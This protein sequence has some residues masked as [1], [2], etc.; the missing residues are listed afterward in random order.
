MIISGGLLRSKFQIICYLFSMEFFFWDN[1]IWFSMILKRDRKRE[2]SIGK[3]I[4]NS[5]SI[6][7]NETKYNL[8]E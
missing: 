6:L 4:E 2:N 3:G 5:I 7:S 8:K 1:E